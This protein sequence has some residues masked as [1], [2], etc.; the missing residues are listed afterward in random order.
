MGQV[1]GEER[2]KVVRTTQHRYHERRNGV[3]GQK[4]REKEVETLGRSHCHVSS[5]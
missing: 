5:T 1:M 4:R 2:K 3:Q